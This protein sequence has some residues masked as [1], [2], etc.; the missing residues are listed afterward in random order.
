MLVMRSR[1]ANNEP[2]ATRTVRGRVTRG[3]L[4]LLEPI[5]LPEGVEVDVTVATVPSAEDV[6]ASRAAAGGWKG[7]SNAEE[8][9]RSTSGAWAELL[10]C[11]EFERAVYE[12]RR[13]HRTP[14]QL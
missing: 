4:A 3:T 10:D 12:R 7:K 2:I 13:Q 6:D 14:V 5:D 1:N 11:E 8:L 9:I